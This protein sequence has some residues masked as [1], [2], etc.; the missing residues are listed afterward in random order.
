[1]GF[2][3]KMTGMFPRVVE[4][5]KTMGLSK[6]HLRYWNYCRKILPATHPITKADICINIL[7]YNDNL[8]LFNLN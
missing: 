7:A 4:E 5:K 8:A 6:S 3:P 2:L 1:M